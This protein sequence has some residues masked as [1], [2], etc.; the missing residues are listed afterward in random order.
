MFCTGFAR[1]SGGFKLLKG[2]EHLVCISV[3]DQQ[4]YTTRIE[5]QSPSKSMA[6]SV[7]ESNAMPATQIIARLLY[8][9]TDYVG[10]NVE[11]LRGA[12]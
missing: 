8:M 7:Q 10:S 12:P 9:S 11:L 6:Q 1:K 2:L 4:V 5:Q 3:D